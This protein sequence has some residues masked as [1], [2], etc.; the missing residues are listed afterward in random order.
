M[1][2]QDGSQGLLCIFFPTVVRVVL[3]AL[4]FSH[5]NRSLLSY[6]NLE[7]DSIMHF[8]VMLYV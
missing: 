2:W 5:Y 4:D 6:Y 8:I 7:P 3:V 1:A